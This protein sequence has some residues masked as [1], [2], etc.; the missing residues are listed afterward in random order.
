MRSR[1]L[2]N[3]KIFAPPSRGAAPRVFGPGGLE[4]RTSTSVRYRTEPAPAGFGRAGVRI[5]RV[6]GWI[7]LAHA[8]CGRQGQSSYSFVHTA[9][10]MNMCLFSR[11]SI[12]APV[13]ENACGSSG[14]PTL[15]TRSKG[16]AHAVDKGCGHGGRR[17]PRPF[18][19]GP[20]AAKRVLYGLT[21]MRRV[22]ASLSVLGLLLYMTF[23]PYFSHVRIN[24]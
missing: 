18:S 5:R 7:S 21:L 11:Q 3:S 8:A 14:S 19:T 22:V 1:R 17:V 23:Y 4:R 6:G 15:W 12:C 16:S 20:A 9:G 24:I 13:D 2:E 10:L